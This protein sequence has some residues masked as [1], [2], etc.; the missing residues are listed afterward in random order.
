MK[1][2]CKVCGYV[3]EGPEPPEI[4]PVCKV[5]KERFEKLPDAWEGA[6]EHRVG[7]AQGADERL[8]KGLEQ[9]FEDTSKSLGLGLAMARAADREGLP[10]I[11]TALHRIA[12]EQALEAARLAELLGGMLTD[13][14]RDNLNARI[15]AG[16]QA[17]QNRQDLVSLAKELGNIEAEAYLNET[18]RDAAR[19]GR[20]LEGLLRRFFN[21]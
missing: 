11:A 4:C 7:A 5:G 21:A 9:I 8:V 17:L 13:S 20:A 19:H 2:I 12:G 6:G 14:T 15:D 1:W 18:V 10:E 3:H 16:R